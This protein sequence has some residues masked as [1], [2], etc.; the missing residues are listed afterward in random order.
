MLLPP[1]RES[2]LVMS[3]R[4]SSRKTQDL[5][6]FMRALSKEMAVL[7]VRASA[8]VAKQN[9]RCF[10]DREIW[11]RLVSLDPKGKCNH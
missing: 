7:L 6:A 8:Y 4:Y 3:A 5:E 2:I 1:A 9:K 10:R 11:R